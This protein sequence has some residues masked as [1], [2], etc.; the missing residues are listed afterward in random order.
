MGAARGHLDRLAAQ[1]TRIGP[2]A[3]RPFRG[4]TREIVRKLSAGGRGTHPGGGR[5][6]RSRRAP[7]AAQGGSRHGARWNSSAARPTACG[8]AT[9]ARCSCSNRRGQIG[10]TAWRFNAWA[11]Y[12]DWELDAAVPAFLRAQ[13]GLPTWEPGM[14]LEG[15]SIDVNGAGLLLTTEECLL[16]PVQ[17]RNPGMSRRDI[18]TTLRDYLGVRPRHLAAQRHRRRRYA[19]P[20]G[21]PGALRGGRHRG[22]GQ[23][24]RPLRREL[25]AAARK[26]RVAARGRPA[27]G[28]AAHAAPAGRSMASACRPATPISTS[29]TAWC[30]S[31]P[32]T[33]PP[34]AW[35]STRW[36]A[37]F[38]AAP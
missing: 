34:T 22:A 8:P 21:R 30:W 29:P 7:R 14:V 9:T 28:Q 31:P 32:S 6:A 1:S 3:S 36:R 35:R 37:S 25:R 12:D 11:K 18:E 24:A 13:L 17:A 5:G 15:G 19:R 10:L 33:I 20:R 23:R 4:S 26:R 16:S 38:P 2:A 27:R